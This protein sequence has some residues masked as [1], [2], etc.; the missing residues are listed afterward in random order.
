MN[1]SEGD[2]ETS[3]LTVTETVAYR[4]GKKKPLKKLKEE[5]KKQES[6]DF[7]HRSESMAAEDWE[8]YPEN[9]SRDQNDSTL[10]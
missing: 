8:R 6:S 5:K 10:R 4:L 3:L 7:R 9:W 1:Y 2:L